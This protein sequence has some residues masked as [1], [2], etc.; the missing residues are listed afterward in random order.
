MGG[1]GGW[2]DA[3]ALGSFAVNLK[4]CSRGISAASHIESAERVV[5]VLVSSDPRSSESRVLPPPTYFM[6][7]M[8]GKFFA[9]ALSV[10]RMFVLF[11][12]T[13]RSYADAKLPIHS[14]VHCVPSVGHY[15]LPLHRSPNFAGFLPDNP[16]DPHRRICH[17][18]NVCIRTD[19]PRVLIYLPPYEQ[20]FSSFRSFHE[21]PSPNLA[22]FAHLSAWDFQHFDTNTLQVEF[23]VGYMPEDA[24]FNDKRV[25]YFLSAINTKL[26]QCFGHVISDEAFSS[27]AAAELFDI[28]TS[29]NAL[30]I[31]NQS[32]HKCSVDKY[33]HTY[34]GNLDCSLLPSVCTKMQ[35]WS[36]TFFSHPLTHFSSYPDHSC[37]SNMIVG[38]S[39]ALSTAQFLPLRGPAA[40][41][42]RRSSFQK[43]GLD[44]PHSLDK[45]VILVH[46]KV[47]TGHPFGGEV[48][49]HACSTVKKSMTVF[50]DDFRIDCV[51]NMHEL[52]MKVIFYLLLR[53]ITK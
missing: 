11:A 3:A 4:G 13:A 2:V 30:I 40:R 10:V 31:A 39:S 38:H 35:D 7:L 51:S 48:W 37:F 42:F 20:R 53:L 12:M 1:G 6:N 33:N 44:I 26:A 25:N 9:P 41:R 28:S 50:H 18:K 22:E 15:A 23:V 16:L 17:L 47:Q 43:L 32:L 29:M 24:Q 49:P 27:F 8:A 5:R 46:E 52:S 21:Q 14:S 34:E 45:H 36:S 19:N